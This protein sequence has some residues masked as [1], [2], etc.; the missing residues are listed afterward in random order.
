MFTYSWVKW[1]NKKNVTKKKND[2]T[3]EA[4]KLDTSTISMNKENKQSQG[5]YFRLS[6]LFHSIMLIATIALILFSSFLFL[7]RHETYILTVRFE[8]MVWMFIVWDF[9]LKII[10]ITLR[11]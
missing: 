4:K 2:N 10:I 9:V 1:N 3:V 7:T 5:K 6:Y 8:M 11:C